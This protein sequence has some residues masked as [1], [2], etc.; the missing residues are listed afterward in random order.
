MDTGASNRASANR[1][2]DRADGV[3]PAAI[4]PADE[5]WANE[6]KGVQLTKNVLEHV[7]FKKG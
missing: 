6:V 4:F 5:L 1:P 2:A 7:I 3:L